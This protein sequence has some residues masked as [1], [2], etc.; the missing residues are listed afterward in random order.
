MAGNLQHA[1]FGIPGG[2]GLFSP[3]YNAMQGDPKDII[4]TQTLKQALLDW[5]VMIQRIAT[6]PTSVLELVPGLPEY[7]GY[8]D[9]SGFGAGGTWLSGSKHINPIVWRLPWPADIEAR[10]VS[11]SNPNGDLTN[12][13]LEM[14]AHLLHW[15]VLEQVAP[16]P[17]G[18]NIRAL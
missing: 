7:V 3:I 4:I 16:C 13:D 5:K 1:S 8:V 17:R 2:K 11:D 12:S 10:L 15:L 9:A 6:R 14:A 18:Y